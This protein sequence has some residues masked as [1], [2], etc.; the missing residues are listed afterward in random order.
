M[1]KQSAP[2]FLFSFYKLTLFYFIHVSPS[3]A[4]TLV[5]PPLTLALLSVCNIC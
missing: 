3:F 2:Q 1:V 5:F 4:P